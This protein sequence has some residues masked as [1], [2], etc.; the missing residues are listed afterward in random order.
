MAICR[1]LKRMHE[2]EFVHRD[3]CSDNILLQNRTV[4]KLID[5]G[6]AIPA[7]RR[8][9]AK[10][11]TP[12]YISPEQVAGEEIHSASDLYSFG[13]VLYELFS[14]RLPFTSRVRGD[15][16]DSI[17]ER[18]EELM[19]QH[20]KA[21][22][23]DLQSIS[24]QLPSFLCDIIMK[25]LDKDPLR[26]PKTA[27]EIAAALKKMKGQEPDVSKQAETRRAKM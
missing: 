14:G 19:Q 6:F 13:V 16:P 7:G 9:H 10:T 17:R 20:L 3:V 23:P 24:P 8:L 5:L 27:G 2:S 18:T 22:P 21:R 15:D 12:S 11:G 26:R 1:A 4:A 25:C